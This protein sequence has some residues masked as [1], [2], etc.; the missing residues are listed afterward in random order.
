VGHVHAHN[1][2]ETQLK[3]GNTSPESTEQAA[4]TEAQDELLGG[5][6]S[7]DAEDPLGL[8]E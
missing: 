8:G 4:E 6:E 3:I 7:V 5:M 2:K 1:T